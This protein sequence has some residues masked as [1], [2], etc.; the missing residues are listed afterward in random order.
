MPNARLYP[1]NRQAGTLG[2]PGL[3]DLPVVFSENGINAVIQHANKAY[4]SAG[5]QGNIYI[6]DGTNYQKIATIP[7]AQSGI[8][9]N[10]T[11]Y[12]NAMSISAQGKLLIGVSGYADGYSKAGIY[13]ID[14]TDPKYPVSFQTIST[15]ST[16]SASVLNIGFVHSNDYQTS[17]IGWSDGATYGVDTTDFRMYASYGGVIETELVPVGSFND[18][19]TFEHIEF[20]LAEPLISG[21][22]I[23][24]SYRLNNK[25]SY[26]LINTW[27]YSTIGGVI[28]FE[29]VAGITDAEYVQLKVELDQSILALY[30]SNIN[31]ISVKLK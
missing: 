16:G 7:Y 26:T 21:Q 4:V 2:N 30:G 28:S 13:E 18:K 20:C 24:I 5:S 23:R 3:A 31:L 14:I 22:N 12:C 9:S 29:D 27:G 25:D 15:L 11:V 8:F 10:S 19:K 17:N 1:W 6:T